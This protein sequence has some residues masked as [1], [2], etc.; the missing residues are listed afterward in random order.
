MMKHTNFAGAVLLLL[1]SAA[2]PAQRR[3]TTQAIKFEGAPQFS[4]DELMAA[5]GINQKARLTAAQA[6]AGAKKLVATG[7]FKEVKFTPSRNGMLFA[8]TP[9]NQLYPMHMENVPLTPGKE[10][11]AKLHKQ[12]PL[13]HGQLP[14]GG[15]MVDGIC[16]SLEEMLAAK[17]I[18]AT[19]KAALT[20]D[21][22][23]KK[24]TA[25]NFTVTSPAVRIGKIQLVGVSAAMQAK[26]SLLASGQMG[27][28]FDTENT[29]AGLE[30]AFEV[31]YQDEGY[32]AVKVDVA[33]V[34]PPVVTD[35]AV[36]V[37]YTVTIKEGGVYKLGSIELPANALV[38]QKE[39][40]KLVNKKPAGAG[41][42]LDL[43]VLTVCEAYRAKGY[44]DCQATPHPSFNEGAHIVN[45]TL[46]IDAGQPYRMGTVKFDEAPAD[47]AARLKRAWKMAEGDVFD[48]RYLS[49]FAAQAQKKDKTLRKW[50]QDMITTYDMKPDAAKHEVDCV[51]HFAKPTK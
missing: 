48:E 24:I 16:H 17:S 27:N 12:F 32:A 31:L 5:A 8:L 34:D 46:D 42:P 2:L 19:V 23:P 13:Y 11:D 35:Q 39:I 45:Y 6:K 15:S 14:A 29:A 37:P 43:F 36:D 41:R 21:L 3:V 4:R 28:S 30:H 25:V 10:L 22:G 20:S 44:M 1:C 7:M 47:M 9:T 49:D 18:K 38:T 26:A 51:F 40:E 33:R 50:M